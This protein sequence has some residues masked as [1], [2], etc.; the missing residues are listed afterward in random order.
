MTN[1]IQKIV[2]ILATALYANQQGNAAV[3]DLSS[4]IEA[5]TGQITELYPDVSLRPLERRPHSSDV[6]EMLAEDLVDAGAGLDA[7][8]AHLAL[9]L[10][11]ALHKEAPNAAHIVGVDIADISVRSLRIEDVSSEEAGI[12]VNQSDIGEDAEIRDVT[13]GSAPTNGHAATQISNTR[14]GRDLIIGTNKAGEE[15]EAR[16]AYLTE[17]AAE[18]NL[19]PW[20]VIHT[21]FADP[22]QGAEMGL[23]DI[24]T[25]LDTTD[26]RQIKREEELRQ[27]MRAFHAAARIP[28]QEM[29]NNSARLLLMG[30]PGS[31]KS[32]FVKHL[33]HTLARAQLEVDAAP[34]LANIEPWGHGLLLPV[35]LELR[36]VAAFA[37]RN[38]IARGD[39]GLLRRYLQELLNEM[40]QSHFWPQMERLLQGG[41]KKN[42]RKKQR[43]NALFL[44]DGLD[45]VPT[46]QRGLMVDMV[47]SVSR[48]YKRH[49]YLVTCRPYAYVGQ[50]WQLSNFRVTTLAPFSAGQIDRFVTNWYRRLAG[51]SRMTETEANDRLKRLQTALTRGD[52][53]GLA[54]RPLLLTVMAQ[55]HTFKNQLPDSR[56]ELYRDTVELLLQRW[57]TRDSQQSTL[58]EQLDLPHLKMSDLEAGLRE[59]AYKAHAQQQGDKGTSELSE[60]TADINEGDLHL[61]LAPYLQADLNRARTFIDYIRERAGLLIR[62]KTAAY[63]FPHRTFQEYLAACHLIDGDDYPTTASELVSSDPSRWREVFLL[64]VGQAPLGQAIAAVNSLCP[65]SVESDA[66]EETWQ[67]VLLAGEALNEIGRNA[68]QR[69]P[70]GRALLERVRTSLTGAIVAVEALAPQE[71][72]TGGRL[73]GRLGDPRAELT[74]LAQMHFCYV[75][76]GPF[77]M[78]SPEEDEN[79]D[80]DE[81]PIHTVDLAYP[82]WIARYPVTCAQFAQFASEENYKNPRYWTEAAA[83]GRWENGTLHGYAYEYNREKE[84]WEWVER[85]IA[86]PYDRGEPYTLPNYPRVDVTWYE[87]LAFCRWLNEEATDAGW[88]PEG[89]QIHLPGEA[90]WEK[91]ARG[92]LDIPL[93]NVVAPIKELA[94]PERVTVITNP[95]PARLYPWGNGFDTNWL[96]YWKTDFD[97]T[98]A[99]GCFPGGVS[100]YGV[101]EMAGNV[102]DWT[103]SLWGTKNEAPDFGYPYVAE[104]GR[105]SLEADDYTGRILRGGSWAHDQKWCRSAARVRNSPDYRHPYV[106]FRCVVVPISH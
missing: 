59:V 105:E 9:D 58:L 43:E 48:R 5:L 82:Y 12:R 95:E 55:L 46:A 61:W 40:G 6:R 30:D 14:V 101:E 83:H 65:G 97:S 13:A 80:A 68:L 93:E 27:F 25:D 67:T 28:A 53:L 1:A 10:A 63:T 71:R 49:R 87:A 103:R 85:S 76:K 54:E 102:S 16:T 4:K 50:P 2:D 35:R 38:E 34:M 57:E 106:G 72:A 31:G 91:A 24:Y 17:M 84:E 8:L 52:L 18:C 11:N 100:P 45:E 32:T 74:T 20:K 75:P 73:L 3:P 21:Q 26:L 22:E 78:G 66:D 98:S 41:T 92:G 44:L 39:V 86:G 56:V 81:K 33:A 15:A 60:E 70:D 29:T 36:Q 94:R 64:S 96:N 69:R 37:R 99:P 104:D 77:R 88:L 7:A 89:H 47:N 62:H 79:A 19:L 42:G 23:A 90:E 51:R